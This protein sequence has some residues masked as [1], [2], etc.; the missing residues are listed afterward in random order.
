MQNVE[1][2]GR[3]KWFRPDIEG[4]RAVAVLLIVA[5]HASVPGVRG[6]FV[7]VDVFYVISGFLITRLLL[8][9]YGTTARIS[10]SHFYARRARRILPAAAVAIGL[11]LVASWFVLAPLQMPNVSKDAAASAL[12]VANYRFAMQATQYFS[13]EGLPSP[14]LHFWSLA[15]EEQFYL[16]WPGLLLLALRFARRGRILLVVAGCASFVAA[17]A[18][19]GPAQP[20]AFFSLPTRAWE[21]LVGAALAFNLDR[22]AVLSRRVRGVAG[23]VGVAAIAGAAVLLSRTTPFPGWAAV[24]PVAGA[25]LVIVAGTGQPTTAGRMLSVRPARGVGAISYSLYLWHWPVLVLLAARFGEKLAPGWRAVGVAVSVADAIGS[26]LLVENPIRFSPQMARRLPAFGMALGLP[27]AVCALALLASTTAIARVENAT[28]T[29]GGARRAVPHLSADLPTT[30]PDDLVP[31]L[32]EAEAEVSYKYV[33]Q[34]GCSSGPY[35]PPPPRTCVTGDTQSA[36]TVML[37][38]DSHAANWFAAVAGA[39]GQKHWR[40]IPMIMNLCP[41]G[42]M[43]PWLVANSRSHTECARWRGAAF[44]AIEQIRPAL[45]IVATG[46]S[47]VTNPRIPSSSPQARNAW[48]SALTKT[49]TR[50]T[51]TT[52]VLLLADTP[53]L[54]SNTAECLSEHFGDVVACS[55]KLGP[56]DP[57]I[58]GEV[59]RATGAAW[60][61]PV[62]W[63]CPR[64]LCYPI[65]GNVLVFTDGQHLSATFSRLM[66]GNMAALLAPYVAKAR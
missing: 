30:V 57:G 28:D 8:N 11:T 31:S 45:V 46:T 50:L 6:G 32:M 15:V 62:S 44:K 26:Y 16:L 66:A 19:T 38:G 21:L 7:G 61:D 40:F 36:T 20:W 2:E 63:L 22:L 29:G 41:A 12:Y 65:Q 42:D 33:F 17:V 56:R 43:V 64:G 24:V 23:W 48:R 25:A 34:L 27:A 53:D 4:L 49:L 10:L 59:A 13:S 55:R 3:D 35:M 60:A 47:Y 54:R 58:D 9:E 51:K 52:R 37:F 39:A 5:F 14:L 18:L 1:H